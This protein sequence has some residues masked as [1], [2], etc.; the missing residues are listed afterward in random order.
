MREHALGDP[1]PPPLSSKAATLDHLRRAGLPI[2]AGLVV[3]IEPWSA[4]APPASLGDDGDALIGELLRA[5]PVIVRS[6]LAIEDQQ[7]TS[8]A[9]L[10]RSIH[11]CTSTAMIFEALAAIA[12]DRDRPAIA[13]RRETL[14]RE[15]P[16]PTPVDQAIIQ[17]EIAAV[18]LLVIADAPSLATTVE[19]YLP[20]EGALSGGSTPSFAGPL[21]RWTD[22][23]RRP[24][25]ALID[26]AREALG[27]SARGIDLEIVIDAESRPWL[28]QARPLTR[29][30]Q[31]GW[32][33]FAEALD[34]EGLRFPDGW[35]RL[36]TEHNPAP[37]SPAHASL[38]AWLASQRSG[39]PRSFAGWLY[40]RVPPPSDRPPAAADP[41]AGLEHLQRIAI[42]TARGRL[43][44]IVELLAS[45]D[46]S[47][48]A[49]LIRRA[50]AAALEMIDAYAKLAPAR[51]GARTAPPSDSSPL[52]LVDRQRFLDV[53]PCT[54]DIASPSLAELADRDH[55][56]H[57][58]NDD[59]DDNDDEAAENDP[60]TIP[61]PAD[62]SAT[63]W[64][65]RELDDHLFAL[66]LAPLRRVYL[67]AA[68]H[69]QTTPARIF[70]L[71]LD[72]LGAA[73][74]GELSDD[75][76]EQI[77]RESDERLQRSKRLRPPP[78]I[79][80][81]APLP[82]PAYGH[83]RGLGIG[84]PCRGRVAQ[85]SDLADLLARPPEAGAILVMPALTVAAAVVLDRLGV[86]ALCS[87][88][89]GALSHAAL[90]VRELGISALIG[91][92]GATALTDG[93]FI[94]LDTARGRIE[95]SPPLP[96]IRKR[97]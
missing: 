15:G 18:T 43:R 41:H 40:E 77:Q 86:R 52:C 46:R 59:N 57:D 65:L 93:E 37:L 75:A 90:I 68:E 85:R 19:V 42:P 71:E 39:M 81:G 27:E 89:G 9:G 80:D 69:L 23:A 34:A 10:G 62:P 88:S 63:T 5:G 25:Q 95:L 47:A 6:A 17:R 44:E 45:A 26:A 13:L 50:Q 53:L 7:T 70:A 83:L 56:G 58:D 36:D 73:L 92:P 74:L 64:L 82:I 67:R 51:A 33:S 29:A 94:G 79:F 60:T 54:W 38:L 78:H 22:R 8:G 55:D 66:G 1:S 32:G 16:G 4:S 30:L 96:T 72:Q 12:S 84:A 20:G 87:A 31:P 97:P 21:A 48:C 91:C 49:A 61:Q 24:T 3:A 14:D 35:W 28:V 2:P 11:G 76:V